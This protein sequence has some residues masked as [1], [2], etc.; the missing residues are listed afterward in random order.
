MQNSY[1]NSLLNKYEIPLIEKH[2][3]YIYINNIDLDFSKSPLLKDYFINFTPNPSLFLES[4]ILNIKTIK[5]LEKH[6]ELLIPSNDRKVNGAFFTPN[7]IIDFIINKINPKRTDKNFDPSCGCG[8]F[9]I[10]LVEF[11]KKKYNKKINV[12]FLA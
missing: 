12:I 9:L 3:I 10:G 6:L 7:Y 8:A 11:Y 5:E 1:L 2:L 4:S